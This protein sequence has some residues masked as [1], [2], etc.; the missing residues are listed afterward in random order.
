MSQLSV[1]CPTC[2]K[3][4]DWL[5]ENRYKPFCSQRCKMIDLGTWA[6]EGYKLH[7][8]DEPLSDQSKY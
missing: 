3:K 1:K 5:P 4:V 8:E 7:S 2:G 6:E